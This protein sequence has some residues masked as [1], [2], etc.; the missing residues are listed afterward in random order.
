VAAE[1][2]LIRTV[3]ATVFVDGGADFGGRKNE[4]I[5]VRSAS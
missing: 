1:I 2:D 3:Q 5:I 4:P